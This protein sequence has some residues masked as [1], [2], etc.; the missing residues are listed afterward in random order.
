MS[1]SYTSPNYVVVGYDNG[2]TVKY[3]IEDLAN[4]AVLGDVDILGGSDNVRQWNQVHNAQ[5]YL[6]QFL[7][8][9]CGVLITQPEWIKG[10]P[11]FNDAGRLHLPKPTPE[12]KRTVIASQPSPL[13]Q[14]EQTLYQAVFAYFAALE[15]DIG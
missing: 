6:E 11:V 3:A 14:A 5:S 8:K 2:K 9:E 15:Q 12:A 10:R 1:T 13:M 7:R 4:G